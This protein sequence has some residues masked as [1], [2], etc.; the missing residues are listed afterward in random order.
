MT[1]KIYVANLGKYNEGVLQGAWFTLPVEWSEIAETI[2]LNAQYEE[3]AIHDYEA[4]FKIEEYSSIS[5][6]NEI[7]E[8]L[9]NV[10]HLDESIVEAIL[11][12]FHDVEEGLKVIENED[13]IVHSDCSD[14]SDIAY[15]Y[16]EET[17]MLAEIEKVLNANYIDWTMIGRDMDIEGTF[18][19]AGN[20][21]VQILS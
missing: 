12:N 4:P 16:Y 9:D 20:G 21:Y 6:L 11:G 14:M 13:F 3:Y 10:D 7:A 15:N 5:R 18:I 17:G 2:G 19:R 1:I 8:L